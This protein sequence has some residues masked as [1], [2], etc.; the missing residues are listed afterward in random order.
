M[1]LTRTWVIGLAMMLTWVNLAVSQEQL[2][3]PPSPTHPA[4]AEVREDLQPYDL[5]L[6]T[7][8]GGS[9]ADL[10][11]DMT[12]D[13]QGNIYVAGIAGSVDF[14]RTPPEIAG[15]SKSGGMVAKFRRVNSAGTRGVP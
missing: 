6:S 3:R 12:V 4:G 5:L 9:G 11:R 7:Y 14:P 15:Q 8:F 2:K 1:K 13:A 10:L